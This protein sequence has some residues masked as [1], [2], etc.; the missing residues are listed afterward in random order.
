MQ[1]VGDQLRSHTATLN[2][3]LRTGPQPVTPAPGQL[4]DAAA[5]ADRG[6]GDPVGALA[7]LLLAAACATDPAVLAEAE[8]VLRS[9]APRRWTLLDEKLRR[10]WWHAPGA[11]SRAVERLL[12]DGPRVFGLALA[13]AHP[14]GH[15]REAAVAELASLEDVLAL[16]ALVLRAADPVPQVRDP[17]RAALTRRLR[18][19]DGAALVGAAPVALVL[20]DRRAGRWLADR[21]ENVLRGG[22]DAT[23]HAALAAQDWRTRRT[24]HLTALAAGRLDLPRLLRAARHDRD[25]LTRAVCAEAAVRTAVAARAVDLVRPLLAN[26]AAVVRAAAV[27]ALAGAGEVGP[28][29][30]ALPDRNPLVRATAQAAA[31]RA[32]LEP[33]ACY[34]ELLA[35]AAP[36]P[37]AIAGLG[38]TG[39]GSGDADLVRPWLTHPRPRGRAAAVRALRR[40]G[41][42]EPAL[43]A[44][45]LTDP[46][47][48]VT[49]QLAVALR[50]HAGALDPA[51]LRGLLAVDQP[52]HVRLA[53]YRLLHARD[54]W[55][56]LLVDLELFTDPS[57]VLRARARNDLVTWAT[58]E[59]ATTYGMPAGATAAALAARLAEA[60]DVL[61]PERSR[62]LRFLLGLR[63]PAG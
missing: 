9:A 58:R 5:V 57:A 37:G 10:A 13:A 41:A 48:A 25:P 2:W 38:E 40:L 53:A 4:R 46:S 59:A 56:R 49:R 39:S 21:I 19:P 11:Y 16:P 33:A 27:Q 1:R 43:L 28:A 24:A 55:T 3:H 44:P 31:R 20:R 47:G 50:P 32:G 63:R 42:A 12:D 14:S 60:E 54:V 62:R 22:P 17:A 35:V 26:G 51:Y 23:L 8:R 29:R 61:G 18:E 7:G 45:L 34:R 36:E 52:G 30:D 15:V 6:P